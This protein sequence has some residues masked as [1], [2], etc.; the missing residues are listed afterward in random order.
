MRCF[1]T[2]SST[3]LQP[4]IRGPEADPNLG[5]D[6]VWKCPG[7][8][9]GGDLDAE[10]REARARDQ[11]A[12]PRGRGVV[13]VQL[14]AQVPLELRQD[15]AVGLR[16]LRRALRGPVPHQVLQHVLDLLGQGSG[17]A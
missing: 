9:Q 12:R 1:L 5:L 17:Q 4:V 15:A 10:P 7:A 6:P 2:P 11:D 3:V 8:H 13:A 16:P 14:R